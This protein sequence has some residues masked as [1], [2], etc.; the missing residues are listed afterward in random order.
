MF[1]SIKDDGGRSV[2]PTPWSNRVK[3]LHP[4]TIIIVIITLT[5]TT[6][7]STIIITTTTITNTITIIIMTCSMG[8]FSLL[9]RSTSWPHFRT[10]GF[11]V[12]NADRTC[13]IFPFSLAKAF[14]NVQLSKGIEKILFYPN[15]LDQNGFHIYAKSPVLTLASTSSCRSRFSHL[16]PVNTVVFNWVSTAEIASLTLL[17]LPVMSEAS[18]DLFT[19]RPAGGEMLL[20]FFASSFT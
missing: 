19:D 8:V 4:I 15:P 17:I 3:V 20:L 12:S 13:D 11:N 10:R 14:P 2:P 9:N 5:T 16:L 18:D 1:F 7:I 6:T